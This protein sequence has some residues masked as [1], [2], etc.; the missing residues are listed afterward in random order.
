MFASAGDY[1]RFAELLAEGLTRDRVPLYAYCL[2]PNHWHLVLHAADSTQ[3]ARLIH[4]VTTRHVRAWHEYRGTAG[5]GHLYQGRYKAFPVQTDEHFI[6]LCRYVERNPVRAG[7]VERAY[8]WRWSSHA[9]H[10]GR[11]SSHLTLKTNSWPVPRPDEW[12]DWVD[13]PQSDSEVAEIR[14]AIRRG[15]PFGD[16]QWRERLGAKT[17]G[18]LSLRRRGRPRKQRADAQSVS[19]K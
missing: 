1:D 9:A 15:T 13:L 5:E 10:I 16:G 18:G 8:Q 19:Q 2:M 17:S 4:W 14:A 6:V 11:T 12:G 7:L 3:I